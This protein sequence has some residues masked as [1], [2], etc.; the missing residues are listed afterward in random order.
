[1]R[2]DC[3]GHCASLRYIV[4]YETLKSVANRDVKRRKLVHYV[5]LKRY[6]DHLVTKDFDSADS[7]IIIWKFY[8]SIFY[9]E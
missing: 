3:N 7:A 2:S 4:D 1:M 5:S 9:K 6:Y 8:Y